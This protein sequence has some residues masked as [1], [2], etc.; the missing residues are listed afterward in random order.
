MEEKRRDDG[1]EMLVPAH[2]ACDFSAQLHRAAQEVG[3]D[4]ELSTK[5]VFRKKQNS[6]GKPP[7]LFC[8]DIVF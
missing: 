7:A 4:K 6:A 5:R 2:I 8:Q 1:V 3:F